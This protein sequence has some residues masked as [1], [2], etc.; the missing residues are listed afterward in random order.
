MKNEFYYAYT[1]LFQNSF[2]RLRRT[3]RIKL[4]AIKYC[5]KNHYGCPTETNEF[6][7]LKK[8][9]SV[10]PTRLLDELKIQRHQ[11]H[12]SQYEF[13]FD[14]ITQHEVDNESSLFYSS[15]ESDEEQTN[16]DNVVD[17]DI[18]SKDSYDFDEESEK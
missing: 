5:E 14:P 17:S 15:P 10:R 7:R 18:N 11:Q 9:N 8:L 2:N 1:Q 4:K 12:S 13:I 3:I 16:L 6:A